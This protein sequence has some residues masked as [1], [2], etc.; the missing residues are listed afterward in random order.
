MEYEQIAKIAHEVNR[1]YCNAIGDDSQPSWED[2][3]QWQRDS[4][5]NGVKF[6]SEYEQASPEESHYSW[7]KEKREQGWKWGPVK[8]PDKKE[9]PCFTAYNEL[10]LEQRVKDYLFAAVCRSALR[11]NKKLNI[12][13]ECTHH[14]Y[15]IATDNEEVA[16]DLIV[17]CRNKIDQLQRNLKTIISLSGDADDLKRYA[18][19]SLLED[20]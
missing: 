3:P 14:L 12:V 18:A 9:H 4:A 6:H 7:M 11:K 10:P 1:A 20:E 8:D 2:A 15:H 17:R 13:D 16:N 19:L 5:I